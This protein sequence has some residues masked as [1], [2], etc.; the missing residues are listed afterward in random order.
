MRLI[1]ASKSKNRQDIFNM[2]GLKY[3]IIT[4]NVEEESSATDPK[5][6]VMDL[7]KGKADSVA[8]QIDG[9]A[10]IIASDSVIYMD[11]KIFEKPKSK[12]EA[13]DNIKSMQGKATYAVTGVTIKDLY[14]NKEISFADVCEVHFQNVADEDITW[15]VNNDKYILDRCGYSIAGKASL[16]VDKVVGD[17]YTVLGMPVKLLNTNLKKLGYTLDDL[18]LI[19]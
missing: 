5:Q 1:L 10:L 12:Q 6:Y 13:F 18:P 17:Y 4:S 3:D 2:L 8:S 15:Y 14:K 9:K 7:S 19:D 16:F 11:G